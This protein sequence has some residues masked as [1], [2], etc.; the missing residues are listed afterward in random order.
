MAAPI[1]LYIALQEGRKADLEVVA[2]ASLAFAQ[3]VRAIAVMHDPFADVRIEL[4]SGTEGSIS[5]NAVVKWLK[6]KTGIQDEL[7]LK[8]VVIATSLWFAGEVGSWVVGEVMDHITGQDAA[9]TLQLSEDDVKKIAEMVVLTLE[10]K[11]AQPQVQEV[12]RELERDSAVAGVGASLAPGKKPTEIVPRSEFKERSGDIG[13]KELLPSGKRSE[14]KPER[15]RI[16]S[17]VLLESKRRRWR[18]LG[19][20]GEFGAPILDQD[21]QHDLLTG[22]ISIPM[23]DGIEMDVLLEVV[24]EFKDG[25]WVVAERNILKVFH[26]YPPVAQQSLLLDPPK[27]EQG[28]DED[29]SP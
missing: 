18:F 13:K 25:V 3:A 9:Q 12:Y 1:S 10:R 11:T 2:R 21:F 26:V 16:I 27:L 22:K 6:E 24:E 29:K 19:R 15:V 7:T 28:R 14:S 23:R 20:T 17:P 5:L 8:A 4:V